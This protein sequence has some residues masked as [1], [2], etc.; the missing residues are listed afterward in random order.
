LPTFA[1]V[2]PPTLFDCL[3]LL[4]ENPGAKPYAGGTDLMVK[5]RD[6]AINP[7]MIV[8]LKKIDKLRG[9]KQDSEG[10]L[11]IGALA[12]HAEISES[13]VVQEKYPFF[14]EAC[15]WV[16]SQQIRNR[17]TIG[18]NI[19]NG[20]PAAETLPS[21]FV[22]NAKIH[23][24]S[25]SSTRTLPIREF[26][27]GPGVTCL[28]PGEIVTAIEIPPI[29]VEYSGSYHRQGRRKVVCIAMVTAAALWRQDETSPS[30]M[31]F[32]I[33]LGSVAPTVVVAKNAENYLNEC[34]VCNEDIIE[35]A[36]MIALK[37]ASPISDIRTTCDYRNDL[38]Y[39]LTKRCLKDIICGG[40]DLK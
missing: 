16:G 7:D 31:R 15:R 4:K 32:S 9:I 23:L 38:V 37:D 19:C 24:E 3:K 20:S 39:V 30:G 29:N 28:Q 6:H 21:L 8:D 18:G 27:C 22:L 34:A 25:V 1:Y 33:A 10:N 14:S 2:C 36:A 11:V 35:K 5:M 17:G 12:T 13:P 26:L 40:R